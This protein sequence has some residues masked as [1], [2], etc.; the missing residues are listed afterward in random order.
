[1]WRDVL[2]W[3]HRVLKLLTW[4]ERSYLAG[5]SWSRGHWARLGGRHFALPSLQRTFER[6]FEATL[7]TLEQALTRQSSTR[8]SKRFALSEPYREPVG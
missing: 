3:R 7:F 2:R 5:K 4:H 8:R 1:M 6:T